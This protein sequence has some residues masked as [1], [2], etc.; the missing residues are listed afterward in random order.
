MMRPAL[1][2]QAGTLPQ[3]AA[4]RLARDVRHRPEDVI[5]VLE[6]SIRHSEQHGLGD[7]EPVRS[8]ASTR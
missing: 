6:T 1:L 2:Q 5:S 3:P 8:Y 4:R 7:P